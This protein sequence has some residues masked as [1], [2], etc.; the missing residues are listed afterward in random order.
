MAALRTAKVVRRRPPV[1][2]ARRFVGARSLVQT[3]SVGLL[4]GM[5]LLDIFRVDAEGR[6]VVLFWQHLPLVSLAFILPVL[7]I[8]PLGIFFLLSLKYGRLFCSWACPQGALNEA[9]AKSHLA[10]WGRRNLRHTRWEKRNPKYNL[11]SKVWWKRQGREWNLSLARYIVRAAFMPPLAAFA[12]VSYV[13]APSQL[14]EMLA[15]VQW[16]EA[17]VLTFLGLSGMFYADLL[18]LRDKTCRVCFFGY[19]QSVASY[20]RP[21]GVVRN[22]ELKSACHGCSACRD[23]CFVGVDPRKR[24]FEWA[25]NQLTF[26]DCISCG[27]CLVACDDVTSRRGV[28]LIMELPPAVSSKAGAVVPKS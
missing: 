10:L 28:P 3:L 6:Y 5:P 22:A 17:A 26:D 2:A 25:G 13:V 21:T 19:L 12:V 16:Q 11:R 23:S 1:V 20:S 9:A 18:F 4:I 7:T 15:G 24:A 27:D 8:L 14:W